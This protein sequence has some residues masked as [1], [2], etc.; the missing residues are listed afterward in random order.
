MKSYDFEA[1]AYDGAVYCIECLPSGVNEDDEEVSPVFADSEWDYYPVCCVCGTI[2]DYVSLTSEGYAYE[3][4][5]DDTE[6]E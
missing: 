4:Q 1:M 3:H 5:N 2:H 6:E